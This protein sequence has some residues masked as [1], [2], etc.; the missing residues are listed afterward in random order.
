[1][2]SLLWLSIALLLPPLRIIRGAATDA[3]GVH[4]GLAG[5]HPS[6]CGEDPASGAPRRI[7]GPRGRRPRRSGLGTG[8]R[9]RLPFEIEPGDNVPPPVKTECLLTYDE[10]NLYAA[11]RAFD[12]RPDQIRAHLADR[13]QAYRDDFVGLMIDPFNDER[14]GFEFFVNPLGV[15][16][17]IARNDMATTSRR[18][19]PGTR[20]GTPR[21]GS[22]ATAMWSRS[23]SRSPRS[24]S[25][26]PRGRRPGVWS[27]SAPI[28]AASATRSPP[29]RSIGS[30]RL[31]LAGGEDRRLRGGDPGAKPRVRSDPHRT[32][33]RR[34]RRPVIWRRRTRRSRRGSPRAGG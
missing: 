25:R 13:D 31:L 2:I 8:P 26:A 18:T 5:A 14:R 33:H 34:Q 19:R 20:S 9:V 15:Q 21:D 30:E 22:P 7:L 16:M 11:F 17:D 4:T 3:D 32:A 10:S 29:S 12:P 27:P 28:P 6:H 1:M 23:R 24:A